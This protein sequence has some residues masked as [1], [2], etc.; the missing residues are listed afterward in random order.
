M[1]KKRFYHERTQLEPINKSF[2]AIYVLLCS[3]FFYL[4][5]LSKNSACGYVNRSSIHIIGKSY[6]INLQIRKS[7]A[8]ILRDIICWHIADWLL[9]CVYD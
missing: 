3:E 7:L 5:I 2:F 8:K 9:K 6:G 1:F 4:V